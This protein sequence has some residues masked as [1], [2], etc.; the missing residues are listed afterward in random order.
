[1]EISFITPGVQPSFLKLFLFW[2][3]FNLLLDFYLKIN[4]YQWFLVSC[5]RLLCRFKGKYLFQAGFLT[6]I[7]SS[8]LLIIDVY[9][10]DIQSFQSTGPS[11]SDT[12]TRTR[13]GTNPKI[14]TLE[15]HYKSQW[16]MTTVF[17]CIN[18]IIITRPVLFCDV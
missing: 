18:S 17:L 2:I 11:S 8:V 7:I 1:M 13:T 4:F 9:N 12:S 10:F 15:Q 5:G 14:L 3:Y 6:I 16:T